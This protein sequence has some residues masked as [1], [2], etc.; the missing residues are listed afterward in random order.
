MHS[1]AVLGWLGAALSM[2]LLWPQVWRSV[3]KGHTNG[4]CAVAC[5]QGVA[6]PVG[7]IVY[8]LL[9]GEAVQVVTNTVTGLAGLLILAVLLV[10]RGELRSGRRLLTGAAGAAAVVCAAA[11]SAALAATT[12]LGTPRVATALGLVLAVA[13]T[14][15]A[16]PQPL[17]LLRDRTQDLAGLSPLRWRL[18]AACTA[19]W[20]AYGVATGQVAVWLSASVGL[21]AALIVCWIITTAGRTTAT[22]TATAPAGA[23]A[24]RPHSTGTRI[25]H[26]AAAF[27]GAARPAPAMR[28]RAA[29]RNPL[30]PPGRPV[31]PQP[32]GNRPFT[33]AGAGHADLAH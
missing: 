3:A 7:W 5:W 30:R 15:S 16:V 6:M 32:G 18:S 10:K 21:A 14:L 19:C 8:G 20:S 1:S 9:T 23:P 12:H 22:R 25:V 24:I 26:P 27:A 4:L 31:R 17:S 28:P 2:T 29:T 33:Q 13:A 11:L